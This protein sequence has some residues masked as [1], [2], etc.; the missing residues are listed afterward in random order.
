MKKIAVICVSVCLVLFS[1]CAAD[2]SYSV[3]DFSVSEVSAESETG[4]NLLDVQF[5]SAY[6]RSL[7]N[8]GLEKL[9]A[10]APVLCLR[11][12]NGSLLYANAPTRMIFS[13]ATDKYVWSLME[14]NK[15]TGH[16]SHACHD[17]LC[18]HDSCL[19]SPENKVFAGQKHLFFIS[20]L[21]DEGYFVSDLD[22]SGAKKLSIP[23]D[24]ELYSDTEKGLYWGKAE[25]VD[26]KVLY[27]LWLYDY[28]SGENKRL[29][30]PAENAAYYVVGDTAYLH[31]YS[32]LVLYR[33]SKDYSK[34]TK[35]A[36]DITYLSD[37]GG[38]LYDYH[39]ETGVLRKLDGDRMVTVAQIPSMCDWWVSEGYV[40]YCC[41]DSSYMESYKNDAELYE[42]LT[43]YNPT[44]GNVYRVREF[45]DTPEL[46]F[47]GSHDGKP[48][49]I[50]HIFA[51]GEVLYIQYRDYE[52]FS[53][54]FAD[55]RG[56]KG[57]VI[58]DSST[59]EFID[60]TNEKAG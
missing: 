27:S 10:N 26:D 9:A 29:A 57:L 28:A 39:A 20:E 16:F 31:D 13:Y 21:S 32:A 53:N 33:F 50:D 5:V 49:L 15:L 18:N 60:I 24:A 2:Y 25:L 11:G 36:D 34:K 12:R 4:I 47:H 44:C 45:G 1:S 7:G 43:E 40:Y 48:D 22:G 54:N 19:F 35:M 55:E 41:A 56:Q 23:K 3:S 42:Y 59:G 30:E 38:S 8:G 51:D 6:Y 58:L 37:F 46:V 14:Y 17:V 52:N